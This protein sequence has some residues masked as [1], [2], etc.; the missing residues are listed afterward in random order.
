MS[1][2]EFHPASFRDP[3]GRV[4]IGAEDIFRRLR[5]DWSE[6]FLGLRDDGRFAA[7]LE[8]APLIPTEFYEFDADEPPFGKT[9]LRH[10]KIAVQTY[11]WEWSF[12]MRRAAA[13]ATLKLLEICL[14]NDLNLKD[15]TSLNVA[16]HKGRMVW[17]DILSV[18]P[19]KPKD[20][21]RGYGQF[22]RTQ[23][24]PLLVQAHTEADVRPWMFLQPDGL[25]VSDAAKI[26]GKGRLFKPGVAQHVLLQ[27]GIEKRLSGK[28]GD[29]DGR[30]QSAARKG[31]PK[32]VLLANARSM[33]RLV[34]KLKNPSVETV[35]RDYETSTSYDEA[36]EAEKKRFVE[37]SIQKL[38]PGTVVDIGCNAGF[39]SMVAAKSA[40]SVISMDFDPSAIDRLMLRDMP[41]E[42]RRKI[43][44]VVADLSAPSPGHGWC[45]TES[46]P[47]L[48]RIRGDFFLALA[49]VHHL[50]I[51]KNVPLQLVVDLLAD[52]APAGVVEWVDKTDDMVRFMLKDR[53]DIFDTYTLDHFR[54]CLETRFRILD[55]VPLKNEDRRLI[56]LDRLD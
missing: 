38:K 33:I 36:G 31:L 3:A 11:P 47:L 25:S 29:G 41:A 13:L 39:Y 48:K 19:L 50:A 21:W 40:D 54:T 51:A 24:F 56:C 26:L 8:K 32:S 53:E 17:F 4:V 7:L 42:I 44:P 6:F 5:S 2:L 23:L 22:C 46:E 15:G 28:S 1:D 20:L 43:T 37:T 12:E 16:L 9:G 52:V 10:E 30:S 55:E 34:E 35:W 18:E 27:A 14:E 45:G 49:L